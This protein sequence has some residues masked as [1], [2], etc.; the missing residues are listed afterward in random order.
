MNEEV[1]YC[2]QCGAK[3]SSEAKFCS[4][5]GSVMDGDISPKSDAHMRVSIHKE[6]IDIALIAVVIIAVVGPILGI[7]LSREQDN[8]Q[9]I[10]D[11]Q[12]VKLQ[13]LKLKINEA[14]A[15]PIIQSKWQVFR[16]VDPASLRSIV[17]SVSI[18]SND[19]LRSMEVD[20]SLFGSRSTTFFCDFP[21]YSKYIRPVIKFDNEESA[22]NYDV[23]G[24]IDNSNE[25]VTG[26]ESIVGWTI[27]N[28]NHFLNSLNSAN[29]LAIKVRPR[30]K[31]DRELSVYLDPVWIRFS[32]EAAKKV[33][34]KLGK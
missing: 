31:Y 22:Q 16:E 2:N 21:I 20:H 18:K 12:Q 3:T 28:D 26:I 11:N 32:L 25:S 19:G 33:I 7:N 34:A 30:V 14:Q 13:E 27:T 9:V 6:P 23:T 29:A 15:S 17:R 1:K 8:K 5:C 10:L 24:A 4:G